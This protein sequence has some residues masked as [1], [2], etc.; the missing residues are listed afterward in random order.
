MK[1]IGQ[2]VHWWGIISE[3][4]SLHRLGFGARILAYLLASV[5]GEVA[6]GKFE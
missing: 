5:W 2:N 4:N 3:V 1:S 6:W